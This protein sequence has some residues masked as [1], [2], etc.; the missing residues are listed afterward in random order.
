MALAGGMC[1]E[2]AKIKGFRGVITNGACRD[3]KEIKGK[4]A[5]SGT[6]DK[7]GTI[8]E[9]IEWGGVTVNPGDI[10]LLILMVL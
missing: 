3:I 7:I 4:Y 9:T 2:V 6:K 10:V 8:R 1:T 5:K